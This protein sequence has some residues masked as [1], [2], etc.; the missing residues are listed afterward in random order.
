MKGT[1]VQAGR[2]TTSP[3]RPYRGAGG[4]GRGESGSFAGTPPRGHFASASP[5]LLQI[6]RDHFV[7]V[8]TMQL[9]QVDVADLAP[10]A[11][12]ARTHSDA[13]IQKLVSPRSMVLF[14]SLQPL[15]VAA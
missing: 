12:S 10:Y 11:A 8:F 15:P 14:D 2:V 5:A 1:R 13:Q 9:E 4:N 6:S 3:G 7:F